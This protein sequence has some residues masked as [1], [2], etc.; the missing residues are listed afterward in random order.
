MIKTP[1]KL[2]EYMKNENVVFENLITAISYEDRGLI[3]TQII[4]ENFEVE[5]VI[6]INLGKTYLNTQLQKNWDK[7]RD[8]LYKLL[9][10]YNIEYKE[11]VCDPIFLSQS[12]KMIT[13][14]TMEGPTIINITTLPKNYVLRL[15]KEF[16][17]EDNIFFYQR[18][19]YR[20]PTEEEL[21]IGIEKILP[22]EGFEGVR[23]LTAEDLLVLIL[24]YEGH[25]ALSFLSKF[26]SYKILPLISVPNTG[27]VKINEKFYKNE[28]K[29]NQKL[30]RKHCVL[31]KSDGSF[32][33]I[34]SLNHIS[35][36]REVKE[37]IDIYKHEDVDICISP[38]GTKAQTLGLYLY[39]REKPETQILYSLPI[40]RFDVTTQTIEHIESMLY[41]SQNIEKLND[42]KN[43]VSNSWIYKIPRVKIK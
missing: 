7:Q 20:E 13:R 5:K 22:I 41:K 9:D 40:K 11:I 17:D 34:S 1:I 10:R 4:L 26:S 31:K 14:E 39:W 42:K 24:G 28:L 27:D 35:F 43:F 2:E 33:T 21:K 29:C 3:S 12:I 23:N 38:I 37:I 36:F 18:T 15:A 19:D 8:F 6:L 30:F 32:F 16:D 25:R